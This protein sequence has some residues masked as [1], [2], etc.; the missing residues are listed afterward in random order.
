MTPS[1]PGEKTPEEAPEKTP[2]KATEKTPE[3]APEKTPEKATEKAGG[4]AKGEK[5]RRRRHAGQ[6]D[7]LDITQTEQPS[8]PK[9][10]SLQQVSQL[11]FAIAVIVF[12]HRKFAIC[13]ACS[14][15][16]LIW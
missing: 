9:R 3:K 2:K 16:D 12:G 15:A 5:K 4:R 11:S 8:P 7:D 14:L 10:P 6:D 13:N 1:P